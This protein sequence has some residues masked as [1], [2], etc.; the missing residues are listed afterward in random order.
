MQSGDRPALRE[1]YRAVLRVSGRDQLVLVVLALAVA[2]LAA[3]P[4]KVQQLA[5]NGLVAGI[6]SERLVF[7]CALFLLAVTAS[8]GLKL[9]LNERITLVGERVVLRLR[10]RLY[11]ARVTAPAGA[12][13][14]GPAGGRLVAMLTGEAETVGQFAGGA[15]A[16]PLVQLGTLA[17][18]IV[19]LVVQ[20]PWLGLLALAVV[21]PQAAIAGMAQ[22]FVD[23]RVAERVEALRAA[24][25][26][27]ASAEP[28]AVDPAVG[29]ALERV[30]RARRRLTRVKL[31]AKAAAT[32]IGGLGAAAV[33]LLGGLLV[34]DG[35]SDV[36]TV[37]AALA[38]LARIER[39]WRD[40]LAFFRQASVVRVKYRLLLP[41]IEAGGPN[42][43][44]LSPAGSPGSRPVG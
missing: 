38:G 35:R 3:A 5:I 29:E 23:A 17:S 12:D 18:V 44:G 9:V 6:P 25:Q 33:L 1:L 30:Y 20:Q 31:A 40:L 15:I 36:G 34:L 10:E 43:S 26:G 41:A 2:A 37:V 11:R 19:F 42:A 7:L 22:R 27:V 39:P 14:D 16:T 24:A 4:L 28:G 8:A 21:A 32:L 13:A